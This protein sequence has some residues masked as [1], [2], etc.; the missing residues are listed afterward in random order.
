MLPRLDFAKIDAMDALDLAILIEIEAMERYK[1]FSQSLGHTGGNDATS[2]FRM[3]VDA[4]GK[5]GEELAARRKQLF[6]TAPT[7]VHRDMVWDAEAP[8]E[9]SIRWGMSQLKALQI[10]LAAEHKAFNYYDEAIPFVT[11]PE[12]VELFKGLRD[13]ETQHVQ[14]LE[15]IIAKLPPEAD[16]ELEDLDD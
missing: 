13:E 8:E 9:G 10:C 2:V 7:R 14:L 16:M 4:E 12:V 6:G 5:H 3:M 11:N 15:G 1:Y